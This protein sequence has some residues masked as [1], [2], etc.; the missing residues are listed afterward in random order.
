VTMMKKKL[1][2]EILTMTT[3]KGLK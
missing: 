3:S 2:L 1:L